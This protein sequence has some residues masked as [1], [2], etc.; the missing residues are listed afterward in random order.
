MITQSIS[1]RNLLEES[2]VAGKEN[3]KQVKDA[4]PELKSRQVKTDSVDF[5]REGMAAMRKQVQDT[6]GH[7]DVEEIM[8]MREILPKIR[9]NPSNDFQWAMQSD[10]QNSLNAIKQ[11]KGSYTL[12]DL[13]AIRMDAYT[14]QYDVL[15]QSYADGS[16]D[17]YVSDGMDENG[18]LQ[19]HKVTEEEDFAYLNEAFERI[20]DS[21]MFSAKSR[22]IQWQINGKFGGQKMHSVP[23]P[24]EYGEKLSGVLKRAASVYAEQTE[25]GNKVNAANLALKYLNEDA[26]FADA[27]HTLFSNI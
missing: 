21:L 6:P 15:K 20:A 27:M 19:Y 22:E 10:I 12:E 26:G 7:I 23:L 25:K 3:L 5:S 24:A 14:G 11:S 2:E 8:Q 16:R 13:I 17:I 4:V 9:M 18:K 1:K